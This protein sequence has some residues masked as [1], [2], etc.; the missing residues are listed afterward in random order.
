MTNKF[1][2]CKYKQNN[3]DDVNKIAKKISHHFPLLFLNDSQMQIY[4]IIA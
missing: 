2:P 3:N 1:N 4:I